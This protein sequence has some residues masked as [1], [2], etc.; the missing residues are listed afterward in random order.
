MARVVGRSRPKSEGSTGVKFTE[1]IVFALL[2][3]VAGGGVRYYYQ[4]L[5]GPG[6]ALDTYFDAVKAGS[7]TRQYALLDDEDKKI[8]PKERDYEQHCQLA[9]GFTE[10]VAD[11]TLETPVIGSN[12]NEA[13]IAATISIR[14]TGE[15]KEL[16]QGGG[17][18]KFA[19]TYFMRKNKEG[20]WKVVLTKSG[21]NTPEACC[22]NMEIGKA[23]PSAAG[24]N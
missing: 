11:R 9:R 18:H 15:G 2:L 23:T 5:K 3:L 20:E 21:K 7:V 4:S 13:T 16:Y 17:S 8:M 22:N 1:M 24:F 6:H 12:P 10:R 14:D 19:D